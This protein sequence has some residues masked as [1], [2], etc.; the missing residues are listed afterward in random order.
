MR[1]LLIRKLVPNGPVEQLEI[2]P[3]D[4]NA[5]DVRNGDVVRAWDMPSP[6][7]EG[8]TVKCVVKCYT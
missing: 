8:E 2:V 1:D 7:V 5:L 4:V 3:E 6:Y